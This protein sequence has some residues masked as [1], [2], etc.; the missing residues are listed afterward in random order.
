[1]P[2]MSLHDITLRK[3]KKRGVADRFSSDSCTVQVQSPVQI[4]S[5]AVQFKIFPDPV[6][7]RSV[8]FEILPRHANQWIRCREPTAFFVY[9]K[10]CHVTT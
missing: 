10:L 5:V 1:M 9:A 2:F 7:F 8:Q 3:Q 6:Q 4:R